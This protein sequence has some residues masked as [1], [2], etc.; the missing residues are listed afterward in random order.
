MS[1]IPKLKEDGNS[2]IE[3]LITENIATE[4]ILIIIS[5]FRRACGDFF[6]IRKYRFPILN[7][8]PSPDIGAVMEI[9]NSFS[10]KYL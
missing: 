7:Y 5:V 4:N 9:L 1:I 6:F 3:L 8:E 2:L 10:T